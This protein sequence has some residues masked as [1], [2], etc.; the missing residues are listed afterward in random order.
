MTSGRVGIDWGVYGVPES[1]IVDREGRIRFK[2]VGPITTPELAP[3]FR[4]KIDEAR[5]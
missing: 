1:F 2:Q 5:R 3:T 4:A